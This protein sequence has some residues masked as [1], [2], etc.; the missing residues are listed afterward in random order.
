MPR[1]VIS[2]R[3]YAQAIFQIATERGEIEKWRGYLSALSQAFLNPYLR[4]VIEDPRYSLRKKIDILKEVSP[5]LSLEALNLAGI[6]ISKGLT[7]LI[8]AIKEDYEE[9]YFRHKGMERV[10]IITA[11]PLDDKELEELRGRLERTRG[12]RLVI[13]HLVDPD[14]VGGI[15]VK[16]GDWLIDGS[17]KAKLESLRKVL[18]EGG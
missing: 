6:L 1:K 10:E 16:G 18:S 7:S 8:E 4:I 14:I 9:L 2:A 17:T 15:I 13:K 3:R 12:K 11:I 5:E